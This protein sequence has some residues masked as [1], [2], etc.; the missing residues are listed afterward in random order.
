MQRFMGVLPEVMI[1]E[2]TVVNLVL[3]WKVDSWS[4]ELTAH[5]RIPGS[6]HTALSLAYESL[7][8]YKLIE[9]L[10]LKSGFPTSMEN[11]QSLDTQGFMTTS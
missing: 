1:S 2:R 4:Q 3:G 6:K 8:F 11:E 5:R 7:M 9:I 10:H